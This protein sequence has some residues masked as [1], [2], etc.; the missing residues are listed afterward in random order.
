MN[1]K[2][3]MCALALTSISVTTVVAA[4]IA[5]G[6]MTPIVDAQSGYLLGA[7]QGKSWISPKA[8][9]SQ[10]KGGE[11]YRLL[12][13]KRVSSTGIGS[14][15]RLGE[16]PCPST[17]F[18]EIKPKQGEIAVAGNWKT[19]P[20]T[21]Q[22]LSNNSPVYR[23]IVADILTKHKI[24]PNVKITKMVRVDLEGD[25]E[26]EV[27]ISAT[28]HK[29]NEGQPNSISSRSLKNEYS[30]LFLRK[31][32]GGK[33]QTQMLSEEYFTKDMEFNA[34][35]IFTMAGVWDLNGDG[36]MEIVTRGRY[37]EG[38]GTTVY[39][40]RGSKAVQVLES[41]CGA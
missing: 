40:M 22:M 29:G 2:K 36:K 13:N 19:Q 39:E 17:F 21:P 38:D 11:T 28:N 37:Y 16:A 35:D 27:L 4:K 9:A 7:S 6:K 5:S 20:R 10:T 3:A 1:A 24:K 18:V 26:A 8:A 14:K 25:G 31:V 30:I 12:E 41:G 15:A 23:K 33:V 32:V 34:P